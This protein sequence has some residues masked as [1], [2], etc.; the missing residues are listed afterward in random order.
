ML[1]LVVY[2]AGFG[3]Y[4]IEDND[5]VAFDNKEKAMEYANSL[6]I[7]NNYDIT[8]TDSLYVVMPIQYNERKK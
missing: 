8:D 2:Y 7:K 6:N 5:V 1:Y 4:E 3:D